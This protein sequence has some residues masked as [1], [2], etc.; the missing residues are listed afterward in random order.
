MEGSTGAIGF[1]YITN[2]HLSLSLHNLIP[3]HLIATKNFYKYCTLCVSASPFGDPLGT[4]ARD[5]WTS[6]CRYTSGTPP[7]FNQSRK[8]EL[9]PQSLTCNF[10]RRKKPRHPPIHYYTKFLEKP[11]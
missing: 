8:D 5:S 6:H 11:S 10:K 2:T 9:D 7:S 3:I 4:K 1:I